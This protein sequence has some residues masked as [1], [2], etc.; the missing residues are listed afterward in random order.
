MRVVLPHVQLTSSAA[1]LCFLLFAAPLIGGQQTDDGLP[2]RAHAQP[3]ARPVLLISSE[4]RMPEESWAALFAALRANLPEAAENVPAIEANPQFL[5]GDDPANAD[6][7]GPVITVYLVGDCYPSVLQMPFPRGARLGWVSRVD[8]FIIPI[9][10][11]DCSQI[12]QE[13]AMQT[14]WMNCDERTAAMSQAIARV[15]LHEW[16][17]VAAQR[18]A[19]GSSGVT[20]ARFGVDDLLCGDRTRSCAEDGKKRHDGLRG[21]SSTATPSRPVGSSWME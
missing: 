20:K 7:A 6:L 9:I 17:H 1:V 3:E 10:H 11:V 19:H 13:I 14:Q 12:R 18:A 8:G 2:A 16:V 5:R 4:H 15:T 21:A